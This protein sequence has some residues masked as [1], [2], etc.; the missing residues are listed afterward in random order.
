M[1]ENAFRVNIAGLSNKAHRFD[2]KINNEFFEK[3]G[4]SIVSKGD[5][6]VD[7]VL[8]KHETFI[9][10]NF[11]IKGEVELVCDRSLDLFMFP[12]KLDKRILFK[13]GEEDME[14]DEE[15]VV[16]NH[17]RQYIDLG[18]YMYEFIGLNIPIKRLHPRYEEDG[19]NNRVIYQSTPEGEKKTIDPRWEKL[20][21]LK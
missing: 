12:L 16:I 5:L 6:N 15:V 10:V 9:E 20:K 3:Y 18:Q 1:A 11:V 13:F 14:V 17:K 8:E 2:Y 7:V 4:D 19:E 21:N